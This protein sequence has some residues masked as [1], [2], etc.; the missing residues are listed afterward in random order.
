MFLIPHISL[1]PDLTFLGCLFRS[2]VFNET[3]S[4]FPEA[5]VRSVIPK[6]TKDHIQFCKQKARKNGNDVFGVDKDI[7]IT[8]SKLKFALPVYFKSKKKN[9]CEDDIK[10]FSLAGKYSVIILY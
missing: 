7:C 2:P 9:K 6:R 10:I 8:G 5:P 1:F 4:L 3:R